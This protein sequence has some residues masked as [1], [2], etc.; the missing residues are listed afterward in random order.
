MEVPDKY[1]NKEVVLYLRNGSRVEGRI[2][3]LYPS[4]IE[5]DGDKAIGKQMITGIILVKEK[6]VKDNE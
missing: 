5:L 1:L 3:N 4:F 6:G 2:T